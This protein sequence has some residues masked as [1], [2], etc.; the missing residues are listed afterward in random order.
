VRDERELAAARV[1]YRPELDG[2]RALAV[3]LVLLFHS[4]LGAVQGG[5]IGVDLF[6]VL[7][8]F[9]ITSVLLSDI[10]VSGRIRFAVFYAR[11]VRRLLAPA[12]L[13]IVVTCVAALLV[14]SVVE[15]LPFKGDAQSALLYVANWRFLSESN[16]YFATGFAKSPFLHFWSL[17]IEEQF[18]IAFPLILLLLVRAGR[19]R[20]WIPWVGLVALMCLSVAAQLYWSGRDPNHAYYGT[21]SRIYQLLAGALLAWALL[22]RPTHPPGHRTT[23]RTI[24]LASTAAAAA[25]AAVVL[26][27]S[28]AIPLGASGRGLAA[29]AAG[30]LFIA[31]L[32]LAP[33][34]RTSRMLGRPVPVY[35]GRISYGTYL[36]HWPVIIV[37]GTLVVVPPLAVAAI[38]GVIATALAAVSSVLLENPIRRARV[39]D[40]LHWPVIATGLAGG[41]A[42][43]VA[44]V[45]P[46]LD[47]PRKPVVETAVSQQNHYLAPPASVPAHLRVPYHA[48]V[49]NLDW[50]ALAGAN[51]PAH[52]CGPRAVQQCVVVPGG[53]PLIVLVGDSHA[54]ML[55][56]ALIRLAREHGF[57]LAINAMSS[58]SWQAQ[59]TNIALPQ[60]EQATCTA[61]RDGWYRDVLPRLRA[62]I[63]ILASYSR[64]NNAIYAHNLVRTGGSN[65]SLHQLIEDTTNETLARIRQAGARPLIL[66]SIISASFDPLDCLARSTYLHQCMVP[67][68]RH[69]PITDR[70]YRAAARAGRARTFDI[71]RIACPGAPACSPLIDGIP[72]WRN[73]NHYTPKILVHFRNQI[74]AAVAATGV[75]RGIP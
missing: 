46:L 25:L 56:P 60:Q 66:D 70:F 16:D 39:L 63:V 75:L 31:G 28:D 1:P 13:V 8:G 37:L 38:A 9:L 69:A 14:D 43:A 52:S 19:C 47:S 29:T 18:Y 44:V 3:Y 53:R 22:R 21:D 10:A 40:R 20:R 34:S 26:L 12:L 4:G 42:V 54:R 67:F 51:G 36:W 50:K 30:V 71:N 6:F 17:G 11:R 33:A 58:C 2:L 27:A 7:S 72:V 73:S 55:A 74:W 5:Y 65:E 57:T 64:D 15:R 62:D 41:V 45:P 49:P 35:L 68:P 61:E 32:S 48:R 24:R 23:G 59:L